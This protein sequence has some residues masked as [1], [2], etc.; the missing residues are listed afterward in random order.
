MRAVCLRMQSGQRAM[1][2]EEGGPYGSPFYKA[3][4]RA[5]ENSITTGAATFNPG[6]TC[7]SALS[8]RADVVTH[9]CRDMAGQQNRVTPLE[10]RPVYGIIQI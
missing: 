5:Y 9:L 2:R 8:P 6:G 7:I 1:R 10:L 3:I 4:L